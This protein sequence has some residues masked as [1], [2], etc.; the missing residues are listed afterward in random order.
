[1]ETGR[2][3]DAQGNAEDPRFPTR[4][5]R[6]IAKRRSGWLH[7]GR[8]ARRAGSRPGEHDCIPTRSQTL[9]VDLSVKTPPLA[10]FSPRTCGGSQRVL[11]PSTTPDP[12]AHPVKGLAATAV[13]R[14]VRSREVV[15]GVGSPSTRGTNAHSSAKRTLA[16]EGCRARGRRYGCSRRGEKE[17]LRGTEPP[18]FL[19]NRRDPRPRLDVLLDAE[20]KRQNTRPPQA[21]TA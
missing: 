12:P 11:S 17:R 21:A 8:K 3:P 18:S 4:A 9:S 20:F 13:A 5:T 14:A 19:K 1:M 10:A 7:G 6:S 15:G 2:C 16:A